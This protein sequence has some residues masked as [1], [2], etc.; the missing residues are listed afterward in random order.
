MVILWTNL[1][2]DKNEPSPTKSRI[3]VA[4]K[5]QLPSLFL[6]LVVH[7]TAAAASSS[8]GDSRSIASSAADRRSASIADPFESAPASSTGSNDAEQQL[9]SCCSVDGS[10][11]PQSPPQRIVVQSGFLAHDVGQVRLLADPVTKP[12][13]P[14]V[15]H[16]PP[17]P[18]QPTNT[19][20]SKLPTHY[21]KDRENIPWKY[22]TRKGRK[23]TNTKIRQQHHKSTP[24][25]EQAH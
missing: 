9:T 25:R 4:L 6:P 10:P 18:H 21:G 23:F 3:K 16:P 15:A 12:S 1:D 5:P 22:Q 7:T 2:G 24:K 20:N 13:A 8:G 19:N 17:K 11:P 14:Q